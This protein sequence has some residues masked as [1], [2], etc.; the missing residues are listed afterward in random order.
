MSTLVG[1]QCQ[2]RGGGGGQGGQNSTPDPSRPRT[3]NQA[4][5]VWTWVSGRCNLSPLFAHCIYTHAAMVPTP[6]DHSSSHCAMLW[7]ILC[8]IEKLPCPKMPGEQRRRLLFLLHY[9][10]RPKFILNIFSPVS[11][12]VHPLE[13]A[14]KR[15][16]KIKS[17]RNAPFGS[18]STFLPILSLFFSHPATSNRGE[19][20]KTLLM[21]G[22][23]TVFF[24]FSVSTTMGGK[25]ETIQCPHKRLIL[26][27]DSSSFF[28]SHISIM[29]F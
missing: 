13:E 11:S 8:T 2:S 24:A 22:H 16:E 10:E 25:D 26:A 17:Q 15:K 1:P 5:S 6:T 23:E 7:W 12:N 3:I 21:G 27:T 20:S 29:R 4:C 19:L 14:W 18:L 9:S 28:S